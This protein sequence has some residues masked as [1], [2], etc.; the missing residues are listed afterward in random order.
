MNFCF[1]RK[2]S[3]GGEEKVLGGICGSG[4]QSVFCH[5]TVFVHLISFPP[6]VGCFCWSEG[7]PPGSN[8]FQ[9]GWVYHLVSEAPLFRGML[10][11]PE[12]FLKPLGESG[13]RPCTQIHFKKALC[14]TH[15]AGATY[16]KHQQQ[17]N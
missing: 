8:P 4:F 16:D 7:C 2:T 5:C 15:P 3:G 12:V 11:S 6:H 10:M 14:Y 1:R 9:K 17:Q 13:L